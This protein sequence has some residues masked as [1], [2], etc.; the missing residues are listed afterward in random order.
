MSILKSEGKAS[1]TIGQ[2]VLD[3]IQSKRWLFDNK[4]PALGERWTIKSE[5]IGRLSR[6]LIIHIENERGDWMRLPKDL[7]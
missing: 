7:F 6:Q 5:H 4:L 1:V 3:Y 2:R